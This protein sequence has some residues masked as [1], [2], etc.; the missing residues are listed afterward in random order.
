VR[1][2][3]IREALI[4]ERDVIVKE[5][6]TG[7]V[8]ANSQAVQTRVLWLRGDGVGARVDEVESG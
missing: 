2:N 6:Q 5:M 3:T 7:A 4:V 8:M 1:R